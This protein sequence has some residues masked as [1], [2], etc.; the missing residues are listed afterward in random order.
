[1]ARGP[2]KRFRDRRNLDSS[3]T[4]RAAGIGNEDAPRPDVGGP[5][6]GYRR[7]MR[8]LLIV[9]MSLPVASPAQPV[10]DAEE[11]RRRALGLQNQLDGHRKA[12]LE[13]G[14]GW[15]QTAPSAKARKAWADKKMCE[16]Y[17]DCGRSL[18]KALRPMD[19]PRMA[20]ASI[21]YRLDSPN[22]RRFSARALRQLIGQPPMHHAEDEWRTRSPREQL[23]AYVSVCRLKPSWVT[24]H[25]RLLRDAGGQSPRP[26]TRSQP[27]PATAPPRSFRAPRRPA[28]SAPTPVAPTVVSSAPPDLGPVEPGWKGLKVH[29]RLA[30]PPKRIKTLRWLP[31]KSGRSTLL[32]TGEVARLSRAIKPT[33]RPDEWLVVYALYPRVGTTVR[34]L[35]LHLHRGRR[36]SAKRALRGLGALSVAHRDVELTER[37]AV[38]QI[39]DTHECARAPG[40]GERCLSR[41]YE[42]DPGTGRRL[43]IYDYDPVR[44]ARTPVAE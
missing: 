11:A 30:V 33:L 18:G 36:P 7:L 41:L 38:K 22:P 29:R 3:V 43:G 12:G 21:C 13:Q 8:T 10:D 35:K 14:Q 19:T 20:Q 9:L 25:R 42:Y 4:F 5:A 6:I 37:G 27:A 39:L 16:L 31:Q 32:D 24:Y 44:R 28:R 15:E 34:S 17:P 1:M 26:Q 23:E 40:P 2:V